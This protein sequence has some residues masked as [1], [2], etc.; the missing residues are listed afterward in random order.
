M[1]SVK[2]VQGMSDALGFAKGADAGERIR[3][4][5][6][7]EFMFQGIRFNAGTYEIRKVQPRTQGSEAAGSPHT[8]QEGE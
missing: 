1:T 5:S 6:A 3:I 4:Y 8:R 2:I 7:S